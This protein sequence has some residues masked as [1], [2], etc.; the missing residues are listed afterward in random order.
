M[1]Q[2]ILF[3]VILGI[4]PTGIKM[5]RVPMDAGPESNVALIKVVI[6]LKQNL[7]IFMAFT[8]TERPGD[9]DDIEY[10]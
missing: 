1:N 5:K 10:N 8:V 4:G 3:V 9:F 7:S 6:G 2:C